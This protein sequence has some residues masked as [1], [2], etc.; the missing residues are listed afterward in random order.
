MKGSK[1]SVFADDRR[2]QESPFGSLGCWKEKEIY[3]VWFFIEHIGC[4]WPAPII[5]VLSSH[6][7]QRSKITRCQE[8]PAEQEYTIA[9]QHS[10]ELARLHCLKFQRSSEQARFPEAN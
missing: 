3:L 1:L 2:Q 7:N 5:N 6:V 10:Q 8:G 4:L 9:D